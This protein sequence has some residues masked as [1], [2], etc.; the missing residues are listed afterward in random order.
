MTAHTLDEIVKIITKNRSK[1][2]TLIGVEGFGGSGKS[3]IA[4]RLAKALKDSYVISI[5]DFIIK[6]HIIEDDWD[7][8]AFD[9]QRL[10]S[11]V[12][13]PYKSNR[14]AS[15]R[16]LEWKSNTLSSPHVIPN[17]SY[18][19]VEGISSYHPSISHYYDYKIWIDTP[20]DIAAS[21]GRLRDKGNEN[22]AHWDLWA[23]NDLQYQQK[24]HPE[25]EADF[26]IKN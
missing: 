4:D 11:E 13:L 15:Y 26:V 17:V 14:G 5:D 19:I 2:R 21:R 25:L 22:E 24:Y 16:K 8:Q 9:R 7:K 18:L 12:L 1:S 20:I 3:T 23:K 6:E 10:A